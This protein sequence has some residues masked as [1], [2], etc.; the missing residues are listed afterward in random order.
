MTQSL[1]EPRPDQRHRVLGDRDP[2]RRSSR[3]PGAPTIQLAQRRRGRD[4]EGEGELK[5]AQPAAGAL[6]P[7][8]DPQL[9]EILAAAAARGRRR[10]PRRPRPCQPLE[11]VGAHPRARRQVGEALVAPAAPALVDER[12]R[13]VGPQPGYVAQPDPHGLALD[14]ALDVAPVDVRRAHLES[15]AAAPRAPARPVDRSPSAA[16]SGAST[17]TPA[18]SAHAARSTGRRAGRR[19]PREPWGTRTPRTRGS[20]RRH[21]RRPPG[22]RRAPW[23]RR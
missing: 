9:P 18:R 13:L 11:P 20:A 8:G 2:G 19:R 12:S 23:R 17:G 16:R 1:V 5:R 6:R 22:S 21:A 3:P 14:G 7:A 15:R 4:R 10:S